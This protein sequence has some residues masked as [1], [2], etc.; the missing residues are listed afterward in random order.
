M[1]QGPPVFVAAAF[2]YVGGLFYDGRTNNLT[3]QVPFPMENPNEMN[4]TVHNVGSPALIA[5]KIQTGPNAQMFKAVYGANIFAQPATTV[6]ADVAS[7]IAAFESST[8]VSPFA[9]KYDAYV[10]G[11]A[12]LSPNEMAGLVLFTGSTTGRPGGPAAT[13]NAECFLCHTINATTAAGPDLF[14]DSAFHNTGVPK[15]PNNPFYKQTS[16][17][18]DP[19]GYNPL[20]AVYIDYGLG[21][22]LYPQAGLPSGNTGTGSNG[23]GDY[24]KING[25]FRASTL[26]NVDKRPSSNFVKAYTHNGFFKSLPQIVHFYNAR[27]LTTVPGEVIDFTQPN[28]YA[29]LKGTPLFP[30]PENL[31]PATLVNPS[32]ATVANGGIVGNLGLS[33]QDEANLVAFLKTLTD[34]PPQ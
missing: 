22:F 34:N 14:S 26:R 15:N 2:G 5:S 25:A 20:G 21:D 16:A 24:L 32:G 33:P 12:Q 28:P 9:S 8:E 13:K 30:P 10:A 7:A 18:A 11:K 31:N 29:K 6:L 19:A 27:N 4:D 23:Q 3:S 17:A 1:V